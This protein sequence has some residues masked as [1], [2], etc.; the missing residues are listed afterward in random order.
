MDEWLSAKWA[1]MEGTALVPFRPLNINTVYIHL[2]YK[3]S[4]IVTIS[5]SH[6]LLD[7]FFGFCD[8][9]GNFIEN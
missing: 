9:V 3:L 5:H 7:Y 1:D 6:G 8:G 2:P 4:G